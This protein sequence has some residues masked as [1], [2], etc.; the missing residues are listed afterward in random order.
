MRS[1]YGASELEVLRM[2][3]V[4]AVMAVSGFVLWWAGPF[5]MNSMISFS[6]G[7][8]VFAIG[9]VLYFVGRRKPGEK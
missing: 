2:K 3:N 4:G 6:I 5:I 8:P 1:Y 9:A 7:F